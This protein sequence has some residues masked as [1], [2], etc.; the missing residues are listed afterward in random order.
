MEIRSFQSSHPTIK[1]SVKQLSDLPTA[2]KPYRNAYHTVIFLQAG[3]LEWVIDF[4]TYPLRDRQV[5]VIPAGSVIRE[6]QSQA[7]QGFLLAFSADFFSKAQEVLYHGFQRFALAKGMLSLSLQPEQ[8]AHLSNYLSLIQ[9]ELKAKDQ[10]NQVF[11]L[12]NLMLAFFN[13][14]ESYHQE[15]YPAQSFLEYRANYQQFM[16]LIDDH[17]IAEKSVGFYTQALQLT[18]RQLNHILRT[19]LGKTAQEVI[20]DRVMLEARRFLSYETKSIKEIAV[21]LGYQDQYYFSR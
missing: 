15:A 16:Q 5:L 11:L 13:K 4:Q 8:S 2:G 12:Q 6:F 21:Q 10:L 18:S 20:L 7:I 1:C 3:K 14:L 17:F 19:I 9:A